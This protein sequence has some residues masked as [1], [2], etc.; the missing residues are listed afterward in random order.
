MICD[1]D[2]ET[3]VELK[4]RIGLSDKITCAE[5]RMPWKGVTFPHYL[6]EEIKIAAYRREQ[7]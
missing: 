7:K 5:Q 6:D 2:S 1:D 3:S 4:A